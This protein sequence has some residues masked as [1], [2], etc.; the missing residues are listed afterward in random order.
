VVLIARVAEYLH[1]AITGEKLASFVIL[2]GLLWIGWYNGTLLHDAH[3]RPD[4]RNR[5]LTFLQMF[6]IAVMAVFA[7]TADADGGTGFAVSY[8]VFLILLTVQWVAVA[9]T[10]RDD[11]MYGPI[12][13]RYTRMMVLMTVWT[14]ASIFASPTGRLW[15]WAAF[16]A[17]FVIGMVIMGLRPE[18]DP[19]AGE[20]MGAESLL[21]RF[22]LF[23]IIVLGEVVA[24]V[25]N[26][27]GS[28]NDLTATVFL[29]G[30]A[31]L[32]VAIA[33][34]WT[35]FDLLAMRPVR[36]ALRPRILSN[37]GQLPLAMA[38]AGVGGATVS[39]IEHT[40]HE[41]AA[42]IW[43]FS[44]FLCLAM[45]AIGFLAWQLRDRAELA[46]MLRPGGDL[47]CA[48]GRARAAASADASVRPALGRAAGRRH[49][50]AVGLHVS[51]L[52][53]HTGRPSET[54]D[55]PGDRSHRQ[56]GLT[57]TGR[58]GRP[59][60][61]TEVSVA[62]TISAISSRISRFASKTTT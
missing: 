26:G 9:N 5:A 19:T 16:V 14:A 56:R 20:A 24:G 38:I 48:G 7:P 47:Q 52:V 34:W 6:A 45:V 28:V 44:G 37:I 40:G 30:F 36:R 27:I 59:A 51:R 3:G 50:R 55:R 8:V 35:Y 62:S 10:E 31:G 43:T 41:D 39:L 33:L 4:M 2:F 12:A 57:E 53:A 21:E 60:Q 11:P 25:V 46:E 1:G 17:Q 22:G 32:A 29:T 23:V 54:S 42:A 13:L 58:P 49:G 61:A 15:M 18:P